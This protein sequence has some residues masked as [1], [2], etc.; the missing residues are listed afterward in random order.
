MEKKYDVFISYSDKDRDLVSVIC[1]KFEEIGLRCWY[2][3][4]DI[5]P[6]E[7]WSG[8]IVGAIKASKV[9]LL[10]FSSNSNTSDEVEK[11]IGLGLKYCDAIIPFRIEDIPLSESLEYHLNNLHWLDAFTDP[12]EQHILS[13]TERV[14]KALP[15]RKQEIEMALK[16]ELKPINEVREEYDVFIS[17]ASADRPIADELRTFLLKKQISCWMAPYSVGIG[18]SYSDSIRNGIEKS[19]IFMPILS[20]QLSNSIHAINE[21]SM[22]YDNELKV[23]PLRI[24]HV[25]LTSKIELYVGNIQHFDF[26]TRNEAVYED[27]AN[28]VNFF[29]KKSEK[30]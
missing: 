4:R 26:Q 6:G 21:I 28:N 17:Y 15:E 27:L 20:N 19:K 30:W 3:Y 24:E 10:V 25:N 7:K 16:E 5:P 22:A 13:L 1:N 11:E 23:I 8:H 29:L 2:A 14:L 18:E 12:R 9:F